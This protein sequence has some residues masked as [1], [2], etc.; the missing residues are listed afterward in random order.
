MSSLAALLAKWPLVRQ[1]RERKDG[2]GVEAMSD[3]TRA[4]HARTDGANVARSICPFC[5]V[6][7]GQLLLA[8][9]DAGVRDVAEAIDAERPPVVAREVVGHE[10][11]AA[12]EEHEA[13]RI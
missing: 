11:P 7:C 4:S 3:K 5:G 8:E 1:I 10:V 13:V 12:T 9:A 6:G 2:T